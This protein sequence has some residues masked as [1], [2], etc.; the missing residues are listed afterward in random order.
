MLKVDRRSFLWGS[1][2]TG[3]SSVFVP[4]LWGAGDGP[5]A[6]T[7]AGKVLGV[8]VGKVHTFKGVPY[9]ASTAI[10]GRFLPPGK[11]QPWGGVR[12]AR[13][14]GN[15]APQIRATPLVPEYG[16]MER[17]GPMSEDC[18]NL[19]I[20]TQ[21]LRDG[22]KRPVM[23]WLHGGG[24]ANGSNGVTVNDGNNLAAKYDVVT[25]NVNHRLNIFGFLCLADVGG[26]A[27]AN[28]SNA[29]MLD[30]VQALEWV[31]DN[32]ANFGG[33]PANVTIFGQSGGGGKVSTL[34]GMP[35]AKGLFHKAIAMSGSAASG[36]TRAAATKQAELV[37]SKLGVKSA[38]DLQKV[39]I[40]Q[41]LALTV[42]P[43]NVGGFGPV[44]DGHS[45]P[46]VPFDPVA[47]EL[48]ANI[49]LMI[50]STETE[51]T[52]LPTTS[53]DPLDDAALRQKVQQAASCNGAEADRLIAVYRKRRPKASNLDL[54]LVLGSDFSNFRTG[55]DTQAERKAA[56][57]KAPVYKYYFQWYSPVRGGALRSMHTMEL[58][59]VFR[60]L[61][62]ARTEV[63]DET[64]AMR[65]LSDRMS[66]AWVGFARSGNPNHKGL[67]QWQP[68][69]TKQRATMVF[70]ADVKAVNDPYAE[71][72]MA[73]E[74]VQRA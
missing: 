11:L 37:M 22:R 59:F 10:S 21:G 28:A 62:I 18:L 69:D 67:P 74:S 5:V 53:F 20:W 52:W 13:E 61:E 30:I 8:T 48:S 31:R 29:G 65:A 34:L 40:D 39:S 44:T 71:E 1:A 6:E 3:G 70:D 36:I 35:A 4:R 12:D 17:T 58:P 45:L 32:I 55:T 38:A 73:R 24:Y 43:G 19:N 63:G 47:T 56:Q 9:G 26:A 42:G 51:I 33:D 49:P 15:R 60:N 57:G 27:F 23:V 50:G 46:A 66:D 2:L 68:F 7:A 25:V 54:Y 16:A 41:L 14:L 72:R 64:P